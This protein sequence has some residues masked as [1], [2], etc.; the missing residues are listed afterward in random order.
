M[1]LTKR[2]LRNIIREAILFEADSGSYT[3]YAH[4]GPYVVASTQADP[5]SSD[6]DE[7][8]CDQLG[9]ELI[10]LKKELQQPGADV[11]SIQKQIALTL[12]TQTQTCEK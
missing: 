7:Q 1:K 3:D 2:Q 9:S 8:M 12:K 4:V 6:E 5:G 10:S 11:Q